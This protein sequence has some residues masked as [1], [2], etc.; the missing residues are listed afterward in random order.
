MS[1]LRQQARSTRLR[2]DLL[3]CSLIALW[4]V[5]AF[6]LISVQGF[7][8]V[9][10]ERAARRQH[11]FVEVLPAR[12]GDIFDRAGRLLATSARTES[13][14]I[15]PSAIEEPAKVAQLL[16]DALGLDATALLDRIVAAHDKRFLWV[17]RRLTS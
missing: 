1:A 16:A 13:L 2:S 10:S 7:G 14:A 8:N 12:P 6:R 4:A 5:I 3:S 9:A 11:A 15:D 17:K